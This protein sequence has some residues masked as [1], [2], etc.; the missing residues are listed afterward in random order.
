VNSA[1]NYR[2]ITWPVPEPV[3]PETAEP[4]LADLLAGHR[5]VLA[6]GRGGARALPDNRLDGAALAEELAAVIRGS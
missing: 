5:P 1:Q 6:R 2:M 3:L 4:V